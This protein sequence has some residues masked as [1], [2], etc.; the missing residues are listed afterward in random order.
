MI[1]AARTETLLFVW[2]WLSY[3]KRVSGMRLPSARAKAVEHSVALGRTCPWFRHNPSWPVCAL[4][5]THGSAPS[6]KAAL[7]EADALR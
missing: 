6:S 2:H 3:G 5:C 1:A 7:H 4:V